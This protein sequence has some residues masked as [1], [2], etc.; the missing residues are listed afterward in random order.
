MVSSTIPAIAH[1]TAQPDVAP[2]F[3]PARRLAGFLSTFTEV[4]HHPP[5]VGCSQVR[6]GEHQRSPAGPLQ[7]YDGHPGLD[8]Q[9][10]L[11]VVL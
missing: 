10:A 9:V 4:S 8:G 6:M 2:L 5:I 7:K 1:R 11:M 3:C